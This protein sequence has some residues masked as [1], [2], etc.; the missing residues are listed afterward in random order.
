MHLREIQ[1]MTTEETAHRLPVVRPSTD[2]YDQYLSYV[3]Q[4]VHDNVKYVS[5][6][7]WQLLIEAQRYSRTVKQ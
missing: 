1:S 5:F 6:V 4:C 3:T 2:N 7:D